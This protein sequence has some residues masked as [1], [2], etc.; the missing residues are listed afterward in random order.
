MYSRHTVD[1]SNYHSSYSRQPTTPTPFPRFTT[2]K[3]STSTSS[4]SFQI[5]PSISETSFC[6]G[7]E[8]ISG[9]VYEDCN[10]SNV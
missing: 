2:Y 9:G 10:L 1:V 3:P 8:E 4:T 7:M 5:L 6:E